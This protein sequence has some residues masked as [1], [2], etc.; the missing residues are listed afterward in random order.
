MVNGNK[1]EEQDGVVTA[2]DVAEDLTAEEGA[3]VEEAAED[4]GATTEAE[5]TELPVDE[6]EAPAADMSVEEKLAAAEAQAAE[7]L[8]GWQRAR[9]EFANAR[10]RL[11]KSRIEARRNATVEVIGRLLPVLDDFGRALDNVPE[12]IADDDWFEGMALIHRKLTGILEAENIEPIEAVGVPFDPNYHEAVMQEES[13]EYES[14]TVIKELQGGY[15]L[16]ERV[17]RPAMVIVA[18]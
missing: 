15:R 12:A 2:E 4:T 11:E 17:I 1:Q 7:Y 16:G 5:P 9:A 13:D 10:K 6:E 3:A 14:G 18:A 8:D